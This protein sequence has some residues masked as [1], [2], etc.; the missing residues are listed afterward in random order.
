MTDLKKLAED[1]LTASQNKSLLAEDKTC[2]KYIL[3]L[4]VYEMTKKELLDEIDCVQSELKQ[5][6]A[7]LHDAEE[8]IYELEEKDGGYL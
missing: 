3:A 5:I 2:E 8:W 6:K 7:K 1:A 4:A